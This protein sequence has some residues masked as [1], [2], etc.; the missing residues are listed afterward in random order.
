[1]AC[2]AHPEC[3]LED[4]A[5]D[6]GFDFLDMSGSATGGGAQSAG[7]GIRTPRGC[8][9]WL[10]EHRVITITGYSSLIVLTQ[11]IAQQ[12][13]M[14]RLLKIRMIPAKD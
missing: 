11:R 3:E 6:V 8:C 10:R 9:A 4:L 1:M 5:E 12:T 2:F 7:G 14:M 13:L